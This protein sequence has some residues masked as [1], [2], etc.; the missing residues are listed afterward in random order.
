MFKLDNNQF[1]NNQMMQQNMQ[2][3]QQDMQQAQQNM[4]QNMQQ[5]VQYVQQDMQQ[6]V[7]YVQQDMQQNMQYAQPQEH[8]GLPNKALPYNGDAKSFRA[9]LPNS[10]NLQIGGAPLQTESKQKTQKTKTKKTMQQMPQ[11][12]TMQQ[13]PKKKH[14]G[15]IVAII[16]LVV[17]LAGGVLIY[18][19]TLTPGKRF[20]RAMDKADRAIE[21]RN[22]S[23]AVKNYKK[24]LD[25]Y[26]DDIDAMYGLLVA[27][28]GQGDTK[29]LEQ[30]YEIFSKQILAMSA[31]DIQQNKETVLSLFLMSQDIFAGDY[32]KIVEE[33]ETCTSIVGENSLLLD[34]WISAKLDKA[35]V[36][37]EDDKESAIEVYAEVLGK[38]PGEET[39]VSGFTSC[40]TTVVEEYI[41]NYLYEQA[42]ALLD[43]YKGLVDTIN[44]SDYQQKI[45]EVQAI[46]EQGFPLM[47]SVYDAMAAGDYEKLCEIDFSDATTNFRPYVHD[48]FLYAPDGFT[49]DYTGIAVGFYKHS[50]G[51]IAGDVSYFYY[52]EYV[53]GKRCGHGVAFCGTDLDTHSYETYDGEWDNDMPNGYGVSGSFNEY[54][55]ASGQTT[56]TLI[57]GNY[58]DNLANGEMEAIITSSEGY[59][60]TG[61]FTADHGV[62]EDVRDQYP[63]Y[64]FGMGEERIIYVVLENEE[65]TWWLSKSLVSHITAFTWFEKIK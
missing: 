60:V 59:E 12:E 46:S 43:K 22:Y 51:E 50:M 62:V 23:T 18:F 64:D 15:L 20:A 35:G 21:D 3:V 28:Q 39:A 13:V 63:H 33:M 55:E 10:E 44:F 58:V 9:S 19:T 1:D 40:W 17:L 25:I 36:L 49:E 45:Y 34:A 47:Q 16:S 29:S 57:S 41:S 27:E 37:E 6:N 4:Q 52:G 8:A 31:D 11:N 56:A 24:A 61:T 65:V 54:H 5:N 53:N 48:S 32:D 7:Q 14:T 30:D 2:N 42:Q 38:Q 26:D